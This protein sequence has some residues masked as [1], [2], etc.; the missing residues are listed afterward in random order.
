M[1]IGAVLLVALLLAGCG[2]RSDAGP[3]VVSAI[4]EAPALADSSQGPLGTPSRLL[5]DSTAQGLVRFDTSGQIE[6]GVAERWIVIDDGMSYIFRL[7]DTEW[8]DGR[9]VSADEVVAILRRQINSRSRNPL[10]PFLSAIDEIVEMTP[11]VIEIRLKRPRPDLL[12]LFAQPEL[13]LFRTRPPGGSGPFRVTE[14][15]HDG[16][17][18][19]PAFD[20]ARSPDD[21]A[22]EPGPEQNVRLIGE[23]AA[24][25]IARFAKRDSDMVTGGSFADWPLLATAEIA[26]ANQRVDPAAGLFGLAIASRA[27]FLAEAANRA[28]VARS[29]DRQAIVSAFAPAWNATAQLLPDRLD[30]AAPPTPGWVASATDTTPAI[31]RVRA[32]RATH[33]GPLVLRIALPPGPGSTILYGIVA[34]GLQRIGIDTQRVAIDADAD[35][36]LIDAVAP[37]DSARWY[38]GTACQPCGADAQAAVEAARDAPTLEQRA[39]RIA[40]ADAA[41]AADIAYIPIARPLRWSLVALRLGQ[42][43]GNS[44]AW[45][46]LNH[47]RNDTK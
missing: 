4:G 27:G 20:P 42:W 8:S 46:P 21:E 16:A 5:V 33:D 14:S 10:L 31:E 9:P 19:R 1:K 6:P 43:Q 36:R 41:V 29:V 28:V 23:R 7:R 25:A 2:R 37:Y 17:M 3:V 35:L 32:W 22:A 44:R 11:Q 12:K 30:S 39:A 15:Y 45:H 34:S 18:L 40:E 13:A 24:R 47:L 38:L 26:P